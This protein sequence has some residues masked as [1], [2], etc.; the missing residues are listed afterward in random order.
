MSL[1]VKINFNIEYRSGGAIQLDNATINFLGNFRIFNIRDISVVNSGLEERELKE[2]FYQA[3]WFLKLLVIFPGIYSEK[4]LKKLQTVIQHLFLFVI[5]NET[6]AEQ[7]G[8]AFF[9]FCKM[10]ENMLGDPYIQ[11][12]P[13]EFDY[14]YMI[15][16]GF[17]WHLN[18]FKETQDVCKDLVKIYGSVW[19]KKTI[20]EQTY[21]DN[22][23]EIGI[24]IKLS[25]NKTI[26]DIFQLSGK[27]DKMIDKILYYPI[28]VADGKAIFTTVPVPVIYCEK[29]L[30]VRMV[31]EDPNAL[32]ETFFNALRNIRNRQNDNAEFNLAKVQA[33]M[34]PYQ[35]RFLFYERGI[36]LNV[37][38]E[39]RHKETYVN[40]LT[41]QS[42]TNNLDVVFIRVKNAVDLSM[43][44][45]TVLKKWIYKAED[46]FLVSLAQLIQLDPT[47]DNKTFFDKPNTKAMIEMIGKDN[48][49]CNPYFH[50]V[51]QAFNIKKADTSD[52]YEKYKKE[53]ASA[54]KPDLLAFI[55][56]WNC[57]IFKQSQDPDF[58][59]G[60]LKWTRCGKEY[61]PYAY[62]DEKE[63]LKLKTDGEIYVVF[64]PPDR[65]TLDAKIKASCNNRPLKPLWK[66]CYYVDQFM[67]HFFA[68]ELYSG[69]EVKTNTKVLNEP[70]FC[71]W[72][73]GRA[74]EGG[75]KHKCHQRIDR[76]RH[77]HNPMDKLVDNAQIRVTQEYLNKFEGVRENEDVTESAT[78]DNNS[79]EQRNKRRY[80]EI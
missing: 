22:G 30:K 60:A 49:I 32:H 69:I 36:D 55:K 63:I 76:I 27:K 67:E 7:I 16:L 34:V 19:Y 6:T 18:Y 17:Y 78:V 37:S 74:I 75:Y 70:L 1:S 2:I 35:S 9:E 20:I 45:N 56:K 50:S 61:T 44:E 79:R 80:G 15:S 65:Q 38:V 24:P 26:T 59:K 5:N 10:K 4:L 46:D 28:Y 8:K 3:C 66:T 21:F 73:K 42:K 57:L 39:L 12:H 72:K 68:I 64:D 51:L 40:G 58:E 53:K 41:R 11:S 13:D 48:F 54:E 33:M 71:V 43:V 25:G 23:D 29:P 31:I 62:D 14:L 77:L 52:T 47:L